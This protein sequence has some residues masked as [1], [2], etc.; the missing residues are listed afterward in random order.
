MTFTTIPV[1]G[2]GL[3]TGPRGHIIQVDGIIATVVDKDTTPA[4]HTVHWAALDGPI[5]IEPATGIIYLP[6]GATVDCI[7]VADWLNAP[8]EAEVA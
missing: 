3:K 5:D 7:R 6:Y 4:G 8:A 1:T 2:D